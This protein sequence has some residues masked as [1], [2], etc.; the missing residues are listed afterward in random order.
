MISPTG[1]TSVRSD[2]KGDGHYG[3]PRGARMHDGTDYPCIPGQ[4]VVA[5]IAGTVSREAVPYADDPKY[6]GLV[7]QGKHARVKLFYLLP[8]KGIVGKSVAEGQVIGTAQD[9]SAKYGKEMTPHIHLQVESYDP[10]LLIGYP[11]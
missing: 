11:G 7:I 3:S 6:R 10:E 1:K 9:I 5:P 8:A 4:Q 2:S